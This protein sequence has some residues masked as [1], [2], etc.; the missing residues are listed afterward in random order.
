MSAKKTLAQQLLD[1]HVAHILK[2]VDDKH[3]PEEAEKLVDQLLGFAD[4][5]KL[6]DI[7]DKKNVTATAIHYAIEMEI[8]P[9]IPELVG[10][11]AR[12][13]YQ[14]KAHDKATLND[15]VNDKDFT[16]IL[17]KIAEMDE[18]RERIIHEAVGNPVYT[19]LVSDLLYNGI[20]RYLQENP[21]TKRI[22]GA[23]SMIKFGKGLMDKAGLQQ[24]IKHNA[25]SAMRESERFLAKQLSGEHIIKNVTQV[26]DKIKGEQVSRFRDYVSEDDVEE[27]FVIGFEFWRNFRKTQ[28]CADMITAGVD[29]FFKKY[30][31]TTLKKL[32]EEFGVDRD[33]IL[34]E[35]MR[36]TPQVVAELNKHGFIEQ[37]A[38][39]Q[40]A[41]FYDSKEVASILAQ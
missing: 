39:V 21:L 9:A 36:Y 1:A 10:E 29:F 25:H 12:E 8:A 31:K 33:I 22:P 40:L 24:Y 14:H 34:A 20:T 11:I 23:A 27:F 7:V 5:I 19:A 15:L 37:L 4:K 18:L 3:L 28:Y 2:R 6:G 17:G 26:W 16:E 35:A 13:L 30:S 41:E 38:R 32:L